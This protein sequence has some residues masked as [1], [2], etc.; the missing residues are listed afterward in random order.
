MKILLYLTFLFLFPACIYAQLFTKITTG[1]MVNDEGDSRSVNWIDYDNDGDLDLFVSNGPH[2]GQNNFFYENNGDGTFT[3]IDTIAIAQDNHASDGSSW[4][5]VDNDGDPDLFVANWWGQNNL[6]YI[7]NG[8]GTFTFVS[9]S[10]VTTESNYSESGVWGDYNSDGFLDLYVCNSEGD[11]KNSLYKNDGDG[12]FTKVTG[13]FL[14]DKLYTRNINWIYYNDDMLPDIFITNENNQD[15]KLYI[16]NGD[17]TFSSIDVPSL[18]NNAGNSTSSDWEDFDNDGDPDVLVLNYSNQHNYLLMNNNDGTFT[19][20]DTPPFSTDTSN[21]FCSAAGDIDN[22]GDLDI[23]ITNAFSG[24][25]PLHN[26][27]YLNKGDGTFT[28]N[29]GVV[30]QD[31]GWSYGCAFGDYNGDGYLDL[32]TANC[33][34]AK[35]NNS[36]YLNNGGSNNWLLLNLEGIKSNR[37]AIGAVIKLKA[38]IFGKSFWQTRYINGETGYCGQNLQVHFGL[39]D[40]AEIDSFVIEWPSGIIQ[41]EKNIKLNSV[42][43]IIEDTSLVTSIYGI[44]NK[45]QGYNLNQNF[46][47]PFNPITNIKFSVGKNGNVTLKVYNLLGNE[48]ST[49]VNKRK[50]PGEYTVEFKGDKLAGGIYFYKLIAGD[51]VSTRKMVL[52]R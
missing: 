7:N 20:V 24:N 5:D 17:E 49:L 31:E 8:D 37:S 11:L 39:G 42:N 30:A 38:D 12:T 22:D 44:D 32:F 46:P 47:N 40:A 34:N 3:K 35:Q 28:R 52:L 43:T 27:L 48:I 16:N 9:N 15:E 33:F 4:G 45:S 14:N 10:P 50:P 2:A 23:F 36:L 26:F 6:L 41:S 21:S 25:A 1:Q 29:T 18:L 13:S 19:K 51:F